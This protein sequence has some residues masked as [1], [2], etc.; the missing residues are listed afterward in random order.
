MAVPFFNSA[1]SA[2]NTNGNNFSG[3]DPNLFLD[4]SI[5]ERLKQMGYILSP[6]S[7][8]AE[9]IQQNAQI[10]KKTVLDGKT[11][12]AFQD[13]NSNIY[14]IDE[15]KYVYLLERSRVD[16]TTGIPVNN[17]PPIIIDNGGLI[18]PTRID[19]GGLIPP[20]NTPPIVP[21]VN[22]PS[23]PPM[24]PPGGS[25]GSGKIYGQ[26]SIDDI[27][28]NQQE[29][30][31]RALWSG[32]IGNLIEFYTSSF[33]TDKQKQYYYEIWNKNNQSD[34]GAQPQF[35]IVYGNALGSGSVDEGGQIEDTPSRA[36]YNQA[37]LLSIGGD[38]QSFIINGRAVNSIYVIYVNRA[39]MLE[40]LDEGNIELNLAH[41][42]GSEYI[43]GGNNV[44][45]YTG[46]AVTVA[47]NGKVL[48]LIDDSS[49]NPATIAQ[50][51]EVYQ[52]ISGSIEDG[53]YNPSSP[54]IFGLMFKR[55]GMIVLDATKLDATA[56]FGTVTGRE[57]NGDNAYK[58]YTAISGAALYDD[59]SG[60]PLGFA[61]R[62]VEK[63]KSTHY[64]VRI[65]NQEFNFSNNKTFTTGSEGD[66][67][68]PSMY[69]D[70][71]V[72]ITT[73]GLYNNNKELIAV[74]KTSK[75]IPKSFTDEALIE[76][77]LEF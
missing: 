61:G 43:A 28:P 53:A 16:S 36:L 54:Q 52:M 69:N 75:P 44:N 67:R 74:A 2:I 4:V 6:T 51:G 42:S 39:R 71:T 29:I 13:A 41:L 31:T 64:W 9:S 22:I 59:G 5:I 76:V 25:I 47:G 40:Y 19:N 48:R 73:V 17:E 35:S 11:I 68:H 72:Y 65:K 66:L 20:I 26:F 57:I 15:R 12:I 21:P 3:Y 70:P 10:I 49:I 46:S 7:Y 33:Q 63:V 24:I 34:C 38:Q 32:N 77:K 62:G 8:T 37:R 50:N 14:V 27:I 55:L 18:P 56:S 45:T 58:L 30:V 1:Q 23:P 60:D